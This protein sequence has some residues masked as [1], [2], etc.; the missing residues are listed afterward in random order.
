MSSRPEELSPIELERLAATRGSSEALL[1]GRVSEVVDRWR[2]PPDQTVTDWADTYRKLSPES[3]AEPGQYSSARTPWV[4]AIQDAAADPEVREIVGA[5]PSQVAKTTILENLLGYFIDRDPAPM[6]GVFGTDR[7]ATTF[8]KDRLGPMVRDTPELAAKVRDKRTSRIGSGS[9]EI[10]EKKFPGGLFAMTGANSAVGL[11]MRPVKRILGD[12]V[13]RWPV[14]AGGKG[15]DEGDPVALAKK[16][17]SNFEDSLEAWM[18]SPGQKSTSRIWPRYLATDRCRWWVECPA[19]GH[20]QVLMWAGVDFRDAELSAVELDEISNEDRAARARYRCEECGDLWDDVTRWEAAAKGRWIADRPKVIERRGFW[21]NALVSPWLTLKG[22]V[23]EWLEAEGDPELRQVFV[24]TRLAELWDDD[25]EKADPDEL[26]ALCEVYPAPVPNLVLAITVG[27][28]CAKDRIE[29][30]RYGWG[31]SGECWALDHHVIHGAPTEILDPQSEDS[32][33]DD[34]TIGAEFTREDGAP[35]KVAATCLDA[36]GGDW[37]EAVLIHCRARR[38][39]NVFA[40][41]GLAGEHVP[42]WPL[43]ATRVKR[44]NVGRAEVYNLGVDTI[45]TGLLRMLDKEKPDAWEPG[46]VAPGAIHFPAAPEFD[47]EFFAQLTGED[48]RPGRKKGRLFVEWI[49][50]YPRVEALDCFVYARAALAAIAPNWEALLQRRASDAAALREVD[51]DAEEE[52]PPEEAGPPPAR[53]KRKDDPRT[54]H[55]RGKKRGRS[56][57]RGYVGDF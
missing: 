12:E 18:S 33:F 36:Q 55:R 30:T 38:V 42:P 52:H 48:R 53:R 20:D 54:R 34:L 29:L 6:L 32:R 56:K 35:L 47:L 25:A 10:L 43:R 3:S 40:I 50:A 7:Q 5:L 41:R 45:K 26:L 39:R 37:Y 22:L 13:D 4:R 46:L 15:G 24:N 28:D 8:S 23:L 27:A 11:A 1:A 14:A 9:S 51:A 19:C 2:P 17:T 44:R 31:I 16:R 21:I 57:G 49:Q